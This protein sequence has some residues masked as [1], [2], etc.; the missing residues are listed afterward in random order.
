MREGDIIVSCLL[1][2]KL[3]PSFFSFYTIT[4]K[5]CHTSCLL[6]HANYYKIRPFSYYSWHLSLVFRPLLVPH[7]EENSVI[8]VPPEVCDRV[9]A[10]AATGKD[11]QTSRALSVGARLA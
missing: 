1:N 11:L 3:N 2:R 6:K 4:A 9:A 5:V 10:V 8:S 7:L